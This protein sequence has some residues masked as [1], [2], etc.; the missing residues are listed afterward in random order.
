[1]KRFAVAFVVALVTTSGLFF[2]MESLVSLSEAAINKP[3]TQAPIE[4]IRLSEQSDLHLKKRHLP[5]KEKPKRPPEQPNTD[6]EDVL[7][8]STN[9]VLMVQRPQVDLNLGLKGGLALGQA[10]SDRDTVPI[11]RVEPM[12]PARAAQRKIEGWVVVEFSISKTGR[13]EN[14]KIL[15]AN[16]PTIFNR[17]AL[18]AVQKWKY[19][20]RIDNGVP[21]DSHGNQTKITFT[22]ND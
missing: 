20:P 12:Y 21:V 16:P 10:P 15:R 18:K 1:M 2:I 6:F 7:S 5:N 4:F 22:L 17:A 13:V 19:K 14:S 11:V 3:P 8:N 9:N